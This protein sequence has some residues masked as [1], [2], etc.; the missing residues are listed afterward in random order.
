MMVVS[1]RSQAFS[2]LTSQS[3][4]NERQN[5]HQ[6]QTSSSYYYLLGS[7]ALTGYMGIKLFTSPVS[8]AEGIQSE[9]IDVEIDFA[10]DLK[11]GEMKELKVGPKDDDKVLISRY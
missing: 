3:R 10:K 7:A 6:R 1:Q 8:E 11:D 5:E 2:M 9:T 4:F